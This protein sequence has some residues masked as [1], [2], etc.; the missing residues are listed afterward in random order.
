MS[1]CLTEEL[2]GCKVPNF[3]ATA[4]DNDDENDV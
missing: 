4:G 2:I 1:V 3:D